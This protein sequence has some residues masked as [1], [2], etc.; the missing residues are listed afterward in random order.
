[1]KGTV[2]HSEGWQKLLVGIVLFAVLARVLVALYYGNGF[3]DIR[4]GTADQ[5]SYDMLAQRVVGGHG[6]SFPTTWWPFAQPDE[7]TAHWSFLYTGFLAV[8][9]LIAGYQ[10]MVA[11]LVQAVVVGIALPVL[12]FRSARFLFGW[13]A[14]LVAAGIS[15]VY[16]Y[17][18]TYGAALMTE[19][20]Y[21]VAVLWSLDVA[22]RLVAGTA[23][24]H[25]AGTGKMTLWGLELG[26]AIGTAILLRQ[27]ILIFFLVMGLILLMW[28]RRQGRLKSVAMAL[29]VA[30]AVSL[31]MLSPA[32]IRNYR[33]FGQW[34]MPNT[35]AGYAFFW[36]NHPIYGTRFESVLSED[37]G[38]SYQELI[39]EELRGL[40][41][42]A[43]DRALLWRGLAFIA[44]DPGRYLLLSLSRIPVYFNFLPSPDSS[45]L[46]NAARVLSLGLFL[47]FMVHGLIIGTRKVLS[48]AAERGSEQD[49]RRFFLLLLLVYVSVYTV[50][51]LLSWANVRYRLPVDAVLILFAG[52]SLTVI[53]EWLAGAMR[54]SPEAERGLQ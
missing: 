47:P 21:I 3:G 38:V 5:I 40:N 34:G 10:P 31:L 15:A 42:A 32:I 51:H 8:V 18:V 50:I 17:F 28:G 11:R 2:S 13:R 54:R 19:A 22:R 35:N 43:L 53:A 16:F 6:F 48:A 12:A 4:G 24:A 37:H 44:D 29:A 14:G 49:A 39:P 33:V 20:F 41:E 9:Y 30:G 46:S 52:Y 7:P 23:T 36:S 26:L 45:L 1:M 27:V 25:S